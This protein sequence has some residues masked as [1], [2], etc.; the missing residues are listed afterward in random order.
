MNNRKL[1]ESRY[2]AILN[3]SPYNRL[4]IMRLAELHLL[5]NENKKSEELLHKLA[6]HIPLNAI[7]LRL[8]AKTAAA[9]GDQAKTH[10]NMGNAF[11]LEKKYQQSL[12]EFL[13][14]QK[15]STGSFYLN[16]RIEARID[17]IKEILANQPK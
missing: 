7:E 4:V 12:S 2:N 6:E 3:I 16:N 13:K 15:F 11:A 10:L 14:A 5:N 17:E 9:Q 8:L 1:A